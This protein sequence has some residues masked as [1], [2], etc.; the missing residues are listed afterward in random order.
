[1]VILSFGPADSMFSF[2]PGIF[3]FI[4]VLVFVF[5]FGTIIVRSIQGAQQWHKNNES[6]VLTVDATMVTKRADVHHY[7]NDSG[8]D[9][10]HHE[11]TTTTYYVTFEVDSGDRMEFK[12]HE[13]EYGMLVENDRGNLTFQG[14]RYL[15]FERYRNYM[16]DQRN[17]E[18]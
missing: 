15:G 11:S 2:V 13:K 4:F 14:T 17:D 10:M 9:N 16:K 3:I 12:I 1:M 18:V 6:P 7:H 8:I 5:I